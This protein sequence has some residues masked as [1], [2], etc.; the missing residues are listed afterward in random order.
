LLPVVVAK[1][2]ERYIRA[3]QQQQILIHW[4]EKGCFFRTFLFV[5]LPAFRIAVPVSKTSKKAGKRK[6]QKRNR[7]DN[8]T[9]SGQEQPHDMTT[10]TGSTGANNGSTQPQ[11]TTVGPATKNKK[12]AVAAARKKARAV[13]KRLEEETRPKEYIYVHRPTVRCML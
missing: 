4:R 5:G 2:K 7:N 3:Q 6:K 13:A 9:P 11:G 10:T 1:E 12:G 8:I